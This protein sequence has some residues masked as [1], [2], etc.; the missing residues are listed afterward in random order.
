MGQSVHHRR[1]RSQGGKWTPG[2]CVHVC[3]DGV[4]GCHGFFEHHPNA[5]R[6]EGFH[7]RGYENEYEVPVYIFGELVFLKDDGTKEL[8]EVVPD[9]MGIQG[10]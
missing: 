6:A 2:N 7:V 5:A 1:K 10:G 9:G 8:A 3:G 4:N